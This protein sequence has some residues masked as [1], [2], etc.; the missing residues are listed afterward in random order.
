MGVRL[1]STSGICHSSVDKVSL[2]I[3]KLRRLTPAA[4]LIFHSCHLQG[5]TAAQVLLGSLDRTLLY[6]IILYLQHPAFAN[7]CVGINVG[8]Q[9]KDLTTFTCMIRVILHALVNY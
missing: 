6:D 2:A 9:P 3:S 4:R 8:F 5:H 1:Y 7:Y